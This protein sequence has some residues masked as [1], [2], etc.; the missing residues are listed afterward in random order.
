MKS[1]HL[2]KASGVEELLNFG[3]QPVC[4]RFLA[5]VK[6]LEFKHP[7]RLGFCSSCGL[8]QLMDPVP[9]SELQPRFDWITYAEP[10]RHLDQMATRIAALPGLGKDSVCYGVSFK[11]D[12]LLARLGQR[13]I[14]RTY[15]FELKKDLGI[16]DSRVGVETVQDR[17]TPPLCRDLAKTHGLADVVVA[18]HI[19]E[20]SFDVF[21]FI[22]AL[23]ELLKPSGYLVLEIPDCTRA[24]EKLDYSTIW[25]EHILYFTRQSF[26]QAVAIGG[27]FPVD[28]EIV[29]FALED[30]L[31]CIARPDSGPRHASA[32][33]KDV[34]EKEKNRAYSFRDNLARR[35]DR[36]RRFF[37]ENRLA[38]EHVAVFGA[39]HLS[40]AFINLLNLEGQID[41]IVDDHP[42][43]QGMF[44]PGSHRPIAGSSALVAGQTRLCLLGLNP[45]SEPKVIQNNAKYTARGGKFVSI[46]P[47]SPNA[48]CL[49]SAL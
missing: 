25:E 5:N 10:E 6:D 21:Q 14:G 11:D 44:M 45:D 9:V 12:P 34:L 36:F 18:R 27:F 41:F 2:C 1:C 29:P 37:S 22:S 24:L 38:R 4:N 49:E 20:H 33:A 15:R 28:F 26:K 19:L 16:G 31:I 47:A 23:R 39:G 7:M 32:P 17:M 35:R 3:P 43:K 30:V 40:C 48:L 13:G 42:K 8:L 46:F